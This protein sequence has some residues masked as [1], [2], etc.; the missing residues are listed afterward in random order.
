MKN[1]LKSSL[2]YYIHEADKGNAESA[3]QLGRLLEKLGYSQFHVQRQYRRAAQGGYPLAWRW[4]GILGLTHALLDEDCVF[5]NARYNTDYDTALLFLKRADDAGDLI[6]Q[7]ILAKCLQIGLGMPADEARAEREIS[8]LVPNIDEDR[9]TAVALLFDYIRCTKD[10]AVVS[11][12]FIAS[13][14]QALKSN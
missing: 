4:L 6:A 1:Y 7:Y 9:I 3:Y 8:R 12:T 11:V 13:A 2:N 14:F 10:T 5:P